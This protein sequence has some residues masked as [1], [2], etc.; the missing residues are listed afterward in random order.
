[1]ERLTTQNGQNWGLN[2]IK[3][4]SDIIYRNIKG[5]NQQI[6]EDFQNG[7]LYSYML[8]PKDYV[9]EFIFNK[10]PGV[11]IQNIVEIANLM[12]LPCELVDPNEIPEIKKYSGT[13]VDYFYGKG[14]NLN[15]DEF[16]TIKILGN[17]KSK[18]PYYTFCFLR[19]LYYLNENTVKFFQKTKD[20]KDPLDYF[21]A[22]Y[23]LNMG[24][25]NS[26]LSHT[27]NHDNY[28]NYKVNAQALEL[29]ARSGSEVAIEQMMFLSPSNV[30]GE[31]DYYYVEKSAPVNSYVSQLIADKKHYLDAPALGVYLFPKEE[32]ENY[33]FVER[34]L[35][36]FTVTNYGNRPIKAPLKMSSVNFFN[37]YKKVDKP[38]KLT[39]AKVLSRHPSH[40]V[41]R[42]HKELKFPVSTLIR[43]GST[44]VPLTKFDVEIN[45]V[46]SIETSANKLLMKEAF[47]KAGVATAD[48]F[49]LEGDS[50]FQRGDIGN[51][52]IKMADLPY[53]IIMKNIYGSRGEGNTKCD[54]PEEL[55]TAINRAKVLKNYIF[56]KFYNYAKEY[57]LHVSILGVFLMWRKLRRSDTPDNQRWFFNNANCNWVSPAHELFD[58]PVNMVE[59]KEE[60][61]KALR[62]VGLTI[63]GVDLRIQ[64]KGTSPKFIVVEINSACSQAELT[65]ESYVNEFQKIVNELSK[66]KF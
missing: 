11:G 48:W 1:M 62:A 29:L 3:I 39:N 6:R 61:V 50:F 45:S 42:K 28:G 22:L 49:T 51:K 55:Q 23:D 16:Y 33:T 54:T 52:P 56:E 36:A 5:C 14:N 38:V 64:T 9:D 30:L 2:L 44:T 57:R 59:A 60:A 27:K 21:K 12:N 47:D 4:G 58:C 25:S 34:K 17:G 20:V 18:R 63:G 53:P 41:F 35:V 40:D 19:I 37:M 10:L 13:E 31:N 26:L 65:A 32:G 24:G 7:A 8:I 66:K 15:F 43:L 46:K